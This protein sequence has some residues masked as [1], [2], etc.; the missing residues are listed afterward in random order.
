MTLQPFCP[1]TPSVHDI[2]YQ[3]QTLQRDL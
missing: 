2:G 3:K 1:F